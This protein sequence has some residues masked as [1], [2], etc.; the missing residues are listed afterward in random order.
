MRKLALLVALL[1]VA[2]AT[3][4]QQSRKTFATT[5]VGA[6]TWV[7]Q[8]GAG[9]QFHQLTWNVSGSNP[10]CQVEL[11]FSADGITSSGT[12]IAAQTCTSNGVSALSTSM[13]ENYVRINV[14]TKSGAGTVTVTY[15]GYTTQPS[16]GGTI[17]GTISVGQE[18]Y[19]SAANTLT[20]TT[21]IID[22]T[23]LAGADLGAKMN[24]CVGLLPSGNGICRGDNLPAS[25]TLSTTVVATGTVVFTFCGQQVGQSA[26]IQFMG[27]DSWVKGCPGGST[28]FTQTGPTPHVIMGG[29][30]DGTSDI[31]FVDDPTQAV[32]TLLVLGM[33]ER[34]I[35]NTISGFGSN[36][37]ELAMMNSALNGPPTVINGNTI[38]SATTSTGS[39][40]VVTQGNGLPVYVLQNNLRVQAAASL[41]FDNTGWVGPMYL[42]SNTCQYLAASGGGINLNGGFL[43]DNFISTVDNMGTFHNTTNYLIITG[44]PAVISGNF[45][46]GSGDPGT[47]HDGGP[48]IEFAGNTGGPGQ[49]TITGNMLTN[50]G[51]PS[52]QG[53]ITIDDR[54]GAT[55]ISEIVISGNTLRAGESDGVH[56]TYGIFF[57]IT[58]A[59][60]TVDSVN[61]TGNVLRDFITPDT[62][63]VAINVSNT[64][65]V[66]ITSL[67]INDNTIMNFDRG[68]LDTNIGSASLKNNRFD[69]TT[70]PYAGTFSATEKIVDLTTSFTNATLPTIANGSLLYCSDCKSTTPTAGSGSGTAVARFN[71]VWSGGMIDSTGLATAA[72]YTT[73]TNCTSAAS[74]AVCGSA[75]AGA[76]TIAATA[77]TVVV[78]SSAVGA[79]S[80]II[81]TYDSSMST[82]LGIT[83]NATEPALYGVTARTAGVSFT[84]TATAPTVNPA[85]FSYFIVNK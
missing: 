34:I 73:A 75:A 49:V 51:G 53:G 47:G 17:G 81:V 68:I 78:Q 84:L 20:G 46:Q 61:I 83:C 63:H 70:T 3:P 36:G 59:M 30:T 27:N 11:D 10:T 4:A 38:T 71:S 82:R 79:N 40:I 29:N 74:P 62:H 8:I 50:C 15:L 12:V 37:I 13:I 16:G 24:T 76:V 48:C 25:Q 19:G 1:V 69:N 57:N 72:V 41:C 65:N 18:G 67:D 6:D 64:N 23:P 52:G 31:T 39:D 35:N 14:I 7:R 42:T 85:C 60:S 33:G 32:D 54:L 9:I 45:I 58:N 21:A 26:P 44:S 22:M 5:V 77:T 2:T 43:T 66:V 55:D 80:D 28:T 56:D